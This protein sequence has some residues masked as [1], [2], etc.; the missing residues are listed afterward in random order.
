MK[1]ILLNETGGTENF[2]FTE[3]DKPTINENEVLI[4]S[5]ALSVNPVDYK[6]RGNDAVLTMIY[7]E[8]RPA[9]LGWDV[10]GVVVDTGSNVTAYKIGDRVFGMVNFLGAGNAY[11]EYVAAPANHLAKIP[12]DRSF[13]DAAASTLAALT[14]LQVLSGKISKNDRVLIHA[15][16]GGVG[17][18]AIQIAKSMGAY[19]ISTSSA[20]NKAF[21]LSL[22]ADEHVDY[23]AQKFEEVLSDID[24]VFDMFNG[25]VLLNSVK[26]VKSGGKVVS[27]PSPE[28]SEEVLALANEKG[29]DLSF[30]MVQSNGDDMNTLAELLKSKKLTPHISKVFRFDEMADAHLQL[31][32]GRTVGKLVVQL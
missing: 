9:I 12:E 28:F 14:A 23:R 16:S 20:K 4:E 10:A 26:V 6:V 2:V 1:A 32:S 13:A 25:E 17:H 31:E 18:F 8:Q 30:H 7:G 27:I 15:G 19:V 24:F 3:I 22:G 29:V 21:I 5:K 11:A